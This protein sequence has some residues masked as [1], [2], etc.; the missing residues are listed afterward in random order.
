MKALI[1]SRYSSWSNPNS[2]LE[3]F[4]L[5]GNLPYAK[6][7]KEETNTNSY[8]KYCMSD[9][10]LNDMD[11]IWIDSNNNGTLDKIKGNIKPELWSGR[12]Y[13]DS[14]NNNTPQYI[15]YLVTKH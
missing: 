12:L 13:S 4:L 14:D 6:V 1:K 11:G 5:I 2:K 9:W 3:G 7:S 10:F 8:D 15:N